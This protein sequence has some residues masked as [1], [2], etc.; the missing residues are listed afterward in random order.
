MNNNLQKGLLLALAIIAAL[1]VLPCAAI[2]TLWLF[3][4]ALFVVPA[5]G[6]AL[7][8]AIAI[9]MAVRSVKE[10]KGESEQ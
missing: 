5:I 2:G 4:Y 8:V 1:L 3:Q 10:K 7:F 9:F 6:I